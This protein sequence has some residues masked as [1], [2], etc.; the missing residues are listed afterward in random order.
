MCVDHLS[1]YVVLASLKDKTAA[2]V[3]HALITNLFCPYSTLRVLLSDNGTEFRNALLEEICKQFN[4]KQTFTV[5]YH[6]ASNGLVERANRKILDALRPVVGGLL[7]TW[8][9]WV[10][11]VA[12]RINGSVCESTG[13]SPFYIVYG[14]E[15]RLPYDLLEGPHKPV[16]NIED[17]AKSQLKVFPDIHKN[18]KT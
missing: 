12:A 4:I 15:K 8:E 3:A 17:C 13:Q 2:A 14:M 18:A 5:T 16:Y 7:E 10:P 6:S 9:D 11:H 1:R